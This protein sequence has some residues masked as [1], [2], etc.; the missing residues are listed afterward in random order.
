MY[1]I[2]GSRESLCTAFGYGLDDRGSNPARGWEDF[3]S[4]PHPNR[5]LRPPS[6]IS[7]GYGGIF[8]TG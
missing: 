8:H 2:L 1:L 7:N 4:S 5:H 6:L 3:S